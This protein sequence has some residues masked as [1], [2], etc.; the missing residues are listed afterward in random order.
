MSEKTHHRGKTLPEETFKKYYLGKIDTAIEH[1]KN[2][3]RDPEDLLDNVGT[4]IPQLFA[5]LRGQ[6]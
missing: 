6:P 4:G 1:A 2:F 5:L 3:S